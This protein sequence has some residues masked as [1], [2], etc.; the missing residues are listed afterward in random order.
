MDKIWRVYTEQLA[1]W[2][3]SRS[4]LL[5]VQRECKCIQFHLPKALASPSSVLL[6]CQG[7]PEYGSAWRGFTYKLTG[8]R[9]GEEPRGRLKIHKSIVG[10]SQMDGKKIALHNTERGQDG[11]WCW[12]TCE[13]VCL[14]LLEVDYSRVGIRQRATAGES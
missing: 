2:D 5:D 10:T 11:C 4:L 9:E 6:L 1:S 14:E 7:N 13:Q 8:R 12:H 3:L